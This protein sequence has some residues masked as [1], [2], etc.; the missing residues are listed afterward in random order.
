MIRFIPSLLFCL[1]LIACQTPTVSP[2]STVAASPTPVPPT[3]VPVVQIISHQVVGGPSSD[4]WRVIGQVKN[5]GRDALGAIKL[6]VELIDAADMALADTT[7]EALMVNLMPGEASPF[8]ASFKSATA[9]TSALVEVISHSAADGQ[10]AQLVAQ[11]DEF[12]LN[13]RGELAAIGSVFNSSEQPTELHSLGFL[14]RGSDGDER[15]VGRMRI[16]PRRLKAGESVPILVIAPENPGAVRWELFHDGIRTDKDAGSALEALDV[17][18]LRM[19]AQGAPF[20]VGTLL[21]SGAEPSDGSV[22]L[23]IMEDERVIGLTEVEVPRPL[24][25]GEQLA[26]AAFGFP[27]ANLRFDPGATDQVQIEVRI[28]SKESESSIDPVSL[29]VDVSAFHSVGSAIFIR[30]EIRNPTQGELDRATVYAEVRS[31]AGELI[32]AGWSTIEGLEEDGSADFV[33]DLPI[34]VGLDA[35][36]TEYDLRAI[37]LPAD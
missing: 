3:A 6:S 24:Q 13:E 21:N 22:L 16:G 35:A 31:T 9:P 30:G 12:F 20:V 5:V 7:V 4:E 37:G 14:G 27:G 36:L 25:P 29:P 8:E 32:T 19:T 10:R 18:Q 33:L 28:E 2:T 26:F 11:M 23:S 17:P 1:L 34:P 15:L